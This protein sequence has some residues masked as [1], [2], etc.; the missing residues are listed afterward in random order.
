MKE[1]ST[2]GIDLAKTIFY[3]HG[4]D[5]SG[6]KLFNKKLLRNQVLEFF[7]NLKPCLVGMEAGGATHYWAREIQKLGHEVKI[8]AP[9][10]VKPY[11][12]SNKTDS[13]DA[14]GICE[15]VTRPSMRFVSFKTIAQQDIQS[16]HRIRER[17][18]K[19]RTALACE[20]RGLLSE[21][22]IVLPKGIREIKKRLP[23]ILAD[24]ENNLTSF[25]R[26]L[27]QDLLTELLEKNKSVLRYDKYILRIHKENPIA[28]RLTTIPGIGELTATA[29]VANV[30]DPRQF[31][32]GREFA[33]Y[34][35]L[36]PK[37]RSSGGKH[38]LLG[39]SKRGDK[40]IRTMLVHGARVM[41]AFNDR[42]TDRIPKRTKWISGVRERR[43]F[44][45]A[46][47]AVANKNAR[48]A[49]SLMMKDEDYNAAI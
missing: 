6:K 3:V 17:L 25:T 49:W 13:N 43:G 42:Y 47:V 48:I 20:I 7:V 10:F 19:S 32:N 27:I 31:K 8:M 5:Q 30:G 46:A 1:L 40:Y 24:D 44:C 16:V 38:N 18:V 36:V 14:E 9:Q 11:I 33:A 35:G 28:Q 45:K 22:G 34:L 41:V 23:D 29:I 37:Q 2:I 39:I 21:Y 15:A 12:K 26:E 4:A